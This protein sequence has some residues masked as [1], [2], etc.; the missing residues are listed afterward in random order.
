MILPVMQSNSYPGPSS[1][2]L[3]GDGGTK[4]TIAFGNLNPK[5]KTSHTSIRTSVAR[6]PSERA[7]RGSVLSGL[8]LENIF[9][10]SVTIPKPNVEYRLLFPF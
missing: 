5:P 7:M 6:T 4:S 10:L 3:K 2:R 8:L 1:A 9:H